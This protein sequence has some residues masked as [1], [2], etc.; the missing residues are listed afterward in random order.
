MKTNPKK[1]EE[2]ESG[3]SGHKYRPGNERFTQDGNLT[4][5]S[6]N[7]DTDSYLKQNLSSKKNGRDADVSVA[8]EISE[9]DRKKISDSLAVLLAESYVLYVKTQ[10]FHWNVTGPNFLTLHTLFM[11]QYV[12]LAQAID[13]VAERIR[14]LGHRAPGT[15]LEFTALATVKEQKSVPAAEEMLAVM[16]HDQETLIR[17]IRRLL[18][19]A[20]KA[21]DHTTVDLL[22]QRLQIHEKAAW[23]LSSFLK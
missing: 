3:N 15:L 21:K 5:E 22:V 7:D 17:T 1:K 14:A 10:N 4:E 2:N 8:S 19:E 18:S 16:H 11:N 13:L 9:T 12:D 20:E 6:P 23:M